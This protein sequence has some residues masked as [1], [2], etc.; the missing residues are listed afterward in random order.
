MGFFLT[1]K[2]KNDLKE[3]ARYTQKEWGIKQR[4]AYLKLLDNAFFSLSFNSEKGISC[5]QIREG[6]RKFFVTSHIIFYREVAH[7]EIEIVR[8]LHQSMD[9]DNHLNK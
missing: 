2:A 9:V 7:S 6:Y 4:D 3:I 5:D 1:N 8:I